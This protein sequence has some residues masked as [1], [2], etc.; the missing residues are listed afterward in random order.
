[1]VIGL[2]ATAL[3]AVIFGLAAVLQ[4]R[5]VRELPDTSGGV[6][7]SVLAALRSR[8][9]LL[10]I[11]LY[12]VGWLLHVVSIARL[13]LFLAQ[14]GIA[15]SLAITA[16]GASVWL[17]E[18][19]SPRHWIGVG[20]VVSGLALLVAAAGKVHS[21]PIGMTGN[22]LLIAGVIIIAALG[23]RW[24]HRPG[25]GLA[26]SVLGGVAYAGSPLATRAMVD[27]RGLAWLIPAATIPLYGILGFWLY[28]V[29]MQRISVTAASTVLVCAEV[30]IPALMGVLLLNDGLD[31][32]WGWLVFPGLALAVAGG[33]IVES[34]QPAPA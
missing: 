23:L 15:A 8:L 27:D 2:F 33:V 13:P 25:H 22:V 11:F 9:L 5:A 10:V 34:R 4:A 29:A 3:F 31:P 18:R 28:S 7:R 26:L 17:G 20:A 6:R 30:L 19:L 14:S 32:T 21:K 24:A 16:I 1:M 12:V